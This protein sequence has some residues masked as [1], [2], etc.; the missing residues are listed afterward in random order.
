MNAALKRFTEYRLHSGIEPFA[1]YDGYEGLIEGRIRKL[2]YADVAGIIM[3]G[4]TVIGSAG[5]QRFWEASYRETVVKW[6]RD[7]IV[8]TIPF[9]RWAGSLCESERIV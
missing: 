8:S 4:G 5:S 2:G 6:S 3:R 9:W 1:V 7:A